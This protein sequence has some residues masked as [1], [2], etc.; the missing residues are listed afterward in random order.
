MPRRIQLASIKG[1]NILRKQQSINE[2]K[3][4]RENIFGQ[5]QLDRSNTGF[6]INKKNLTE[7]WSAIG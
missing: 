5:M 3:V 4:W 7:I 6:S 2:V 1:L